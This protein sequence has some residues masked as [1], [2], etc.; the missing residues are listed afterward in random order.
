[1]ATRIV[2][3]NI[4]FRSSEVAR[5]QGG[6]LAALK[7]NLV[8]LQEVNPRSSEVLAAE[9]G[10]DWLVR[11][12]D[13][14]QR[15]P[16][17]LWSGDGEWPS[18][19]RVPGRHA[20]T[21]WTRSY[22]LSESIACVQLEGLPAQAITYHAPPGVNFG[23]DIP[24]QAVRCV[25]WSASTDGPIVLGADANTPEHDMPASACRERTGTP[26]CAARRRTRR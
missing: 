5:R 1:M 9:G 23:I 10:L 26:A 7:P 12:V 24:R 3:L 14:R 25:K 18:A 21:S 11:S 8:L 4:P 19:E 22:F 13:L 20:P 6:F 17:I 15:N 2:S 16:V